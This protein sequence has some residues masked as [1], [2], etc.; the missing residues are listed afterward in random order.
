[1]VQR[2]KLFSHTLPVRASEVQTIPSYSKVPERRGTEINYSYSYLQG[3]AP[4]FEEVLKS[5]RCT[6]VALTVQ[7]FI[8][9]YSSTRYIIESFSSSVFSG[10]VFISTRL[11][12]HKRQSR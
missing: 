1:M 10:D 7:H 3:K 9:N 12:V 6:A 2:I 8:T 11:V 4:I 5:K